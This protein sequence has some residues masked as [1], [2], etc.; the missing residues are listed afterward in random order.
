[1]IE[2]L[3]QLDTVSYLSIDDLRP[4]P[5]NPRGKVDPESVQELA[6]SIREQ[7]LLQ[8]LLATDDGVVVA[9]HRRLAA[10]RVAGLR[11]VPVI[12]R[13]LSMREQV[14]IMCVENCQRS[15]LTPVQEAKAYLQLRDLGLS[16]AQIATRTGVKQARITYRLQLLQLDPRLQELVDTGDLP[17]ACGQHLCRVTDRELQRKLGLM[18]V[19]RHWTADQTDAMIEREMSDVARVKKQ[20]KQPNAVRFAPGKVTRRAALEQLRAVAE[21]R[22]TYN[23]IAE[24][25]RQACEGDCGVE[26]DLLCAEC[27]LLLMVG[28][29]LARR[30]Q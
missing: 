28:R 7:G 4:H 22:A 18:A 3:P 19:R 13:E 26:K 17:M 29:L 21:S 1:M 30:E 27:P 10:A 24:A 5:Q 15:D 25:M 6:D 12:V 11:V 23:V 16:N 2:A 8:P 14:E 9:G 20:G